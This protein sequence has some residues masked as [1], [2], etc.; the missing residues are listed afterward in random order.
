MGRFGPVQ[1]RRLRTAIACL[2]AFTLAAEL[3]FIVRSTQ[4]E[5]ASVNL[6]KL[7]SVPSLKYHPKVVRPAPEA[8]Q[9]AGPSETIAPLYEPPP[10]EIPP[11]ENHS[12]EGSPA[13]PQEP[14]Q[15]PPE[16]G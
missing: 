16:E 15:K 9:E 11:E 10:E 4:R 13:P 8:P 3:T 2:V 1:S 7:R 12:E 14:T 6:P 5:A